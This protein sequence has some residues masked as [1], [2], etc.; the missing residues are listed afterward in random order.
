MDYKEIQEISS[1]EEKEQAL[2]DYYLNLG[3][4]DWLYETGT[5]HIKFNDRQEHRADL[6]F[7]SIEGPA[8]EY[9]NGDKKYYLEG[10]LKTKKE[11]ERIASLLQVEEK[12]ARIKKEG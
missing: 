8:I 6:V 2:K 9:T 12:I 1:L 3:V 4:L 5:Q 7:H 10:E 11:W